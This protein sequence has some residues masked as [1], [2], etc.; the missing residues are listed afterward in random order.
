[1]SQ[2][3]PVPPTP[4]P[5]A[6]RAANT[7]EPTPTRGRPSRD[8]PG[9]ADADDPNQRPTRATDVPPGV[10]RRYFTEALRGGRIAYYEGPGSKRIA[11]TDLGD[12]LVTDQ[13]HPAVIRDLA[14]IAAHRGWTS[15]QVRGEDEFRRALWLEAGALGLTVKG[16]KPQERDLQERDRRLQTSKPAPERRT[17]PPAGGAPP[18]QERT[19]RAPPLQRRADV[20][21][22]VWGLLLASGEA[23]YR[24]RAGAPPTPYLRIDRGEGPLLDIWGAGLPQALARSG[25]QAGDR[26]H[27]RRDGVEIVQK[28]VPVRDPRTGEVT[29]TLRDIPRNRW[30]IAAERFRRADPGARARDPDLLGA[31]SHL[32]ILDQIIDRAVREPERRARLHAEARELVAQELA[33]GRGFTPARIREVEPTLARDLAE[34]RRGGR[35]REPSVDL[36][37]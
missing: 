20:D 25:A 16:Y 9:P 31:Q 11:F 22:G 19:G 30:T 35:A 12:R 8:D 2:T 15:I 5:R 27:V 3:D 23:P 32:R 26:V 36:S 7:I 4:S 1:M 29:Q 6:R 14:A 37:R 21:Q 13:S 18:V 33:R 17:F 28:R 10:S 34:A 24:N